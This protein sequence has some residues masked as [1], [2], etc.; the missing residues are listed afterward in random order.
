MPPEGVELL[1]HDEI[2]RNEE[3]VR[4]IGVFASLGVIKV[5]FTG[6]EPL[7]RRGMID[8]LAQTRARHPSLELCLTTNGVLLG[9]H[10]GELAR[11]GVR[12]L[13]VSCDTVSREA[14]RE[15]TMCD[16]LPEV[17]DGIDRALGYGSFEIK[18]NAV[19]SRGTI[20]GLESYLDYFCGRDVTLRFIEMMPFEGT[21]GMGDFI[22]SDELIERLSAL[23]E[24]ARNVGGDTSVAVMYE[25]RYRGTAPMRIGIIPPVTHKFCS[26]CN[27]LRLTSD[28]RLRTCL[29]SITDHDLKG[30]LRSG[31][32]DESLRRIIA[33]AVKTKHEGHAMECLPEGGGC[34]SFSRSGFMSKI[35]G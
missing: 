16:A 32:D 4:L 29:H 27:R 15:I 30:P 28:G 21:E 11:L 23:G 18:I 6:G 3:F 33:G 7:L 1:S 10:I 2:L 17:L 8:I 35:G 31:A 34:F 19:L 12:K 22:P 25:Y 24:L 20:E 13:N 14:Y 5:R 26:S 9:K